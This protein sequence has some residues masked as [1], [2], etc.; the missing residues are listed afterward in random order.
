VCIGGLGRWATPPFIVACGLFRRSVY[1]ERHKTL[2]TIS[3]RPHRREVPVHASNVAV[4]QAASNTERPTPAWP[5]AD[6]PPSR[7]YISPSEARSEGSVH[8]R[9]IPEPKSGRRGPQSAKHDWRTR[10]RIA[11]RAG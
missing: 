3:H 6:E 4:Q 1:V 11:D 5:I 2:I 9:S 7:G 8:M 10:P